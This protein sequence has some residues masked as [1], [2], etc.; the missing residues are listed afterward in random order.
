M[1]LTKGETQLSGDRRIF[2][3]QL[4]NCILLALVAWGVFGTALGMGVASAAEEH[5]HIKLRTGL[6]PITGDNNPVAQAERQVIALFRAKF[7]WIEP[8]STTGLQ[9]PGGQAM[10]MVP[11]MQIA[12]DMAPDLMY[13]NFRQSQTYISM[14]LLYPLDEYVEAAAKVHPADGSALT[15]EQ[16]RK[17]LEKGAGWPELSKRLAEQTWEVMRRACPYGQDCPYRQKLGQAPLEKH[18][19]VF[20]FPVQPLVI[21]MVYDKGLIAEYAK[22]GVKLRTPK[23]WDELIRWAKIMTNPPFEYGMS[24]ATNMASWQFLSFLYSAGGY[25]VKQDDNGDWRC[26]IDSD[27]AAEAAWF[28]ARLRLEKVVRGGRTYRGVVVNQENIDPSIRFAYS[29]TY[30]D[31]QFFSQAVDLSSKGVG[32]VPAGPTGLQR[33][34]F[35]ARMVGIFSGLRDDPQRRDAA[36]NYAWFYD[37][38]EAR[39][40]RM[41][42]MVEMGMGR[43]VRPEI[44]REFN[45]DGRYDDVIRQIPKELNE[46]Y[47][48]AM[49]GGVPEPY[50]KNCQYIYFEL[51][52]PLGEIIQNPDIIAAVDAGDKVRGKAIIRGILKRGQESINQRLLGI[53]PPKVQ[54]QRQ[55]VS[56]VVIAAVTLIFVWVFKRVYRTFRPPE[57]IEAGA[58][59][60]GKY[61]FA[62]ILLLPAILTIG[63]WMYWPLAKGT[64]IAFQ[65][66]S[67]LGDSQWVGS[68]QF[69]SVLFDAEFWHSMWLSLLYALMYMFFG[70]WV[71]IALAFLLVEVPRGKAF[72]RTIYYLPAVLSG[73]VVIFLW[74][75]FYNGDGLINQVING[76]IVAINAIFGTHLQMVHQDWLNNPAAALLCVL[77]PTIW[78]GMGPGCLI[79]LAALKT[80]PDEIYE[81]A[82]LD[83]AGIWS[84][85]FRIA[86]PSIKALVMINFIGAMIGA[87]RG[88]SAFVLAMTGGGPYNEAGG[89]TEVI[90]LH[91]FYVTFGYLKFGTGA[92]MAW[93]LGAMLIGFTVVQL[94]RLSQLEF[95]TAKT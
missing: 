80:V 69:A 23:N 49:Q 71:P 74:R 93:V 14:K 46:T 32:A 8:V 35:N 20:A 2:I 19:H 16:Y 59:Q 62:Y 90:G 67:V 30:L 53:L 60:F 34:E 64:L 48:I 41:E 37:G 89:A 70:F 1:V 75:S 65:D 40:I 26:V 18:W 95:K 6:L 63:M 72:F 84:K 94:Q 56:W 11:F 15:T 42:Y 44:L 58:W 91:I 21:A 24:W 28:Y 79:Y 86:I 50:G 61:R 85:V 33:S 87:V 55:I 9:L 36:W 66:Y 13:V 51:N 47:R 77:L 22:Q 7:P 5:E 83:G 57:G 29:Y 3:R 73:A 45:V 39:K 31:S 4:L 81:A 52:K 38:P 10:D 88:S 43:F 68:S 25:V 76:P 78:V 17:M 12:G 27:E 82:D 54:K 92:A